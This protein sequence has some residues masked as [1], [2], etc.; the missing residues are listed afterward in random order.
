MVIVITLPLPPTL[1]GPRVTCPTSR[2][3][4]LIRLMTLTLAQ[5]GRASSMLTSVFGTS[6]SA[7]AWNAL[8]G[9]LIGTA[10]A[11]VSTG[12]SIGAVTRGG[13]GFDASRPH[14]AK[15]S[16]TSTHPYRLTMTSFTLPSHSAF[17]LLTQ[18]RAADDCQREEI[19]VVILLLT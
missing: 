6:R 8:N 9:A 1:I 4:I 2:Q 3:L 16:A 18:L 10:I 14:A 7:S 13:A 12:I 15:A 17:S 11:D 5:S 19:R